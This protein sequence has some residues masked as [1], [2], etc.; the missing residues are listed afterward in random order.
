MN[1]LQNTEVI[2]LAGGKGKRMQSELPKAL[3]PLNGKAFLAHI[4]ETLRNLSP[5]IKPIIVIG[6]NGEMIREAL[7]KE[8]RYAIQEEQLGTGH[9][10]MCAEPLSGREAD[11]VLVLLADQPLVSQDTLQEIINVH[12]EKRATV[13]IAT[14]MV[15]DL[16]DWREGLTK[17]GRIVRDRDSKIINIIEYK[18]ASEAEKETLELNLAIYA[19]DAKW[20]WENIHSLKNTNAQGEYYLTDMVKIACE[21]GRNIETVAVK[22]GIEAIHPNSKEELELLEK[23]MVK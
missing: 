9:A 23:L 13:T 2:I 11:T 16:T 14:I 12:K 8:Q 1:N 4:L 21:Q 18:D 22:N 7:G 19:F 20:L 3:T 6:H 10:V 15:P 17:F 5:L